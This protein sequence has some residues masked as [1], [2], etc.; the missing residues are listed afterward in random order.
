MGRYA[1]FFVMEWVV[2]SFFKIRWVTQDQEVLIWLGMQLLVS[3]GNKIGGS[4]Y[5]KVV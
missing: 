5:L 2:V 1:M 3:M 4:V